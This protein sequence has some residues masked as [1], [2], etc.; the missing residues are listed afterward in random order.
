[1]FVIL[2]SVNEVFFLVH[3]NFL[4]SGPPYNMLEPSLLIIQ[5][6]SCKNLIADTVYM[7]ETACIIFAQTCTHPYTDFLFR[8]LMNLYKP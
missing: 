6:K 4:P 8:G 5:T 1:M 7:V 2:F 3:C